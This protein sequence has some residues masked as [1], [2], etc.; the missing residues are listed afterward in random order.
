MSKNQSWFIQDEC[1]GA[2]LG[3][4]E[5]LPTLPPPLRPRHGGMTSLA[6]LTLRPAIDS[7]LTGRIREDRSEGLR[8]YVRANSQ[9]YHLSGPVQ[10]VDQARHGEILF[11]RQPPLGP[12]TYTLEVAVHDALAARSGVHRSSFVVPDSTPHD[13][14]VSNLVLVE[15]AERVNPR[16]DNWTTRCTPARPSFIQ[17]WAN[18][19]G[20]PATSRSRFTSW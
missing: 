12:S 14:Q 13:L 5:R 16:T 2:P 3:A 20:R 10:Q 8:N 4:A 15:R 9:P 6:R 18:R 7:F 17:T 11:F 19:S 1:V